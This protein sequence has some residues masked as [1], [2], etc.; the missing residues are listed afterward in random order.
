AGQEATVIFRSDEMELEPLAGGLAGAA[1]GQP[2]QA[3]AP[4]PAADNPAAD[5]L[6]AE[7]SPGS[8]VFRGTVIESMYLG[9]RVRYEVRVGDH[10]AF[11]VDSQRTI[12]PGQPVSLRIARE[13]LH[14][15]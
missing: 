10:A 2:D 1:G 12:P 11:V 9:A 14:V 8:Y 6:S 5:H 4:G 7:G 15:F 13:K 3:A